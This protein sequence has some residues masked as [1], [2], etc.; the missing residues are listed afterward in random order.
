MKPKIIILLTVS[1]IINSCK[2]ELE[3]EI[4]P[5]ELKD[6]RIFINARVQDD[7]YRFMYDTGA[8]GYGRIDSQ[9]VS[10]FKGIEIVGQESNYD[11]VN[12]S[13][14]NR[15]Q[16]DKISVGNVIH[17]DIEMLSRNYNSGLDSLQIPGI[18]GKE[19]FQ[20]YLVTIDYPEKQIVLEDRS[21]EEYSPHVIPFSGEMMVDI[22]IGRKKYPAKIDTGS[23]LSLHIPL[24][25]KDD[26][27]IA[28]LEFKAIGRRANTEFNLYSGNILEPII[29]ADQKV[30]GSSYLFSKKAKIINI[31][32]GILKDYRI[33]IDFTNNLIRLI[34]PET[35]SK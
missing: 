24:M 5:F 21:L 11:G 30:G 15:V 35:D 33:T 6:N 14:I 7:D 2:P 18:I 22:I 19:F 26:F 4:I 12:Y 17:S 20:N 28:N 27:E 3:R 13:K 32:M 31:G 8:S 25:Y 16:V 34:K 9:L 23:S 1:F 29:L 10:R